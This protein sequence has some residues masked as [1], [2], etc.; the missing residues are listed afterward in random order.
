MLGLLIL[1]LWGLINSSA[2]VTQALQHGLP[3]ANAAIPGT[4]TVGSSEGPLADLTLHEVEI[5]DDIGQRAI[6][7]ERLDLSFGLLDLAMRRIAVDSLVVTN[8]EVYVRLRPDGG[9][10]NLATAFVDK[11]K[12]KKPKKPA[13]P[14]LKALKGS[15]DSVTI[16]GATVIVETPTG[17]PVDLQGVNVQAVWS[18]SRLVHDIQ[19]SKLELDVVKPLPLEGVVVHGGVGLQPDLTLDMSD[20]SVDWLAAKLRLDGTLGRLNDLTPSV[21]VSIDALDLTDVKQIAA[22]APLEGTLTGEILVSGKLKEELRFSGALE[23]GD[24]S[25]IGLNDVRLRLPGKERELLEYDADVAL[26][27]L[28]PEYF[29]D[30]IAG[31][32]ADLTLDLTWEGK[33]TNLDTLSGHLIATGE[34]FDFQQ[35]RLGPLSVDTVL[36]GSLITTRSLDI[37]VGGGEVHVA[38]TTDVRQQSF[39]LDVDGM[40]ADLGALTGISKGLVK[41]GTFTFD[42]FTRGTWG[43]DGPHPF[44][45]YSKMD[46]TVHALRLEPV[47]VGTAKTS[48]EVD[49]DVVPGGPPLLR[50]TLNTDATGVATPDVEQVRD[51]TAELALLGKSAKY[52]VHAT[53]AG[54]IVVD[55]RGLADWGQLPHIVVRGDSLTAAVGKHTIESQQPFQVD[56]KSGALDI[57]GLRLAAAGGLISVGASRDPG[58]GEIGADLVVRSLD[59]SKVEPLGSI[60]GGRADNPFDHLVAGVVKELSVQV[61]GTLDAPVI[62]AAG[63]FRGVTALERPPQDIELELRVDD[64]AITGFT[65]IRELLTLR[66]GK[67]PLALSLDGRGPTLELD[68]DAHWDVELT[69]D[70]NGLET[71]ADL[72]AIELPDLVEGGTYDGIFAFEGPTSD[73]TARARLRLSGLEVAERSVTS[74]FGASLKDGFLEIAGS[75]LKADGQTIIELTGGA[76]APVS[77]VLLARLGPVADRH[78]DPIPFLTDLK[79]GADLRKVDM[80][81]V[82]VFV[83]GLKPL[84]G[85]LGGNVSITGELNAPMMDA[86]VQLRGGRAGKQELH[87]IQVVAELKDGTLQ[88]GFVIRPKRGGLLNVEATAPFPLRF[89]PM[90]PMDELLGQDG[91]YVTLKGDGFPMPVLL[92]FVPNIWESEG[93]LTVEGTVTGSIREPVPK[94]GVNVADGLVCYKTTGICYEQVTLDT[95]VDPGKVALKELSFDTVPQVVNPID[96]ARGGRART[97]AKQRQGFTA[98]GTMLMDGL[99][100]GELD[101]ELKFDR[102]WALYT[103]EFQAQLH[104]PQVVTIRGTLPALDIRGDLELQ[105]VDVDL[106]QDD[107]ANRDIQALSLPPNLRVHRENSVYGPGEQV[108][109]VFEEEPEAGFAKQFMEQ[110]TLDVTIT[111]TNNIHVQLNAGVAALTGNTT[112]AGAVADMFGNIKPDLTLAGEVRIQLRDGK[113]YLEGQITTGRGSELTVLTKKFTVEVD[114]SLDFVGLIADTQLNVTA[115]RPSDYGDVEVVVSER[116]ASPSIDFRS[117]ELE[118]QADIM[119]VLI[120]GKPLSEVG[121]TEGGAA[122]AAIAQG[123]AGFL[124][125]AFGKYVP[126]DSLDFELGDDLQS[127]S[128]EAGKAITPYI[129]FIARYNHGVENDENRVEGQLEIKVSRR[130]YVEFRIGDRLE[131]AAELVG[132]VIF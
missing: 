76:G 105:N 101:V 18:M 75:R 79:L 87:P 32:P 61:D 29:L 122:Y 86:N 119:S 102:M 129:F 104:S 131:G 117:D 73:P 27:G 68:P 65:E 126:V 110:S 43:G 10:V 49:M 127:F 80:S 5:L 114:S 83:G 60:L 26:A 116:L 31:L 106:G 4:I 72:A 11:S 56:L 132:K 96:L 21:E 53:R 70:R 89:Q 77:D 46:T 23:A 28:T 2:L 20:L 41:G 15:A 14:F 54:G 90:T 9:G 112:E 39:A 42:G 113:P 128:V 69:I 7:V 19:V 52:T 50:G 74:T 34:P 94:I 100:L 25:S 8:P 58:S 30:G 84:T 95:R 66:L 82:H 57:T 33:G 45:V 37:G 13:S 55:T 17:K 98:T 59:L 1:L 123:L 64:G 48:F 109:I 16:K 81:L 130:A 118:D 38:G 107:V 22:K 85:A 99:T 125:Q 120:T 88:S 97:G 51:V 63:S 121:T 24:G 78:T 12:P 111:L 47:S 36:D 62:V 103:Q 92:A 93:V 108:V 6:Y 3:K 35:M 71:V 124:T 91:L 44:S 67:V 115:I 40:I